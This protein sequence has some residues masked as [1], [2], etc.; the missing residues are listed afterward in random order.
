MVHTVEVKSSK[1]FEEIELNNNKTI[2]FIQKGKSCYDSKRCQDC[3]TS[4]SLCAQ[5]VSCITSLFFCFKLVGDIA[6]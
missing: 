6:Q 5:C 3:M 4:F 1:Q 2:H